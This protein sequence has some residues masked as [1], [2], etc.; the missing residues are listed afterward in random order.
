MDQTQKKKKRN[1]IL[2]IIGISVLILAIIGIILYFVL[3][4]GSSDSPPTPPP[5]DTPYV[6]FETDR[7]KFYSRNSTT[8]TTGIDINGDLIE[9]GTPTE[10]GIKTV[11]EMNK[12]PLTYPFGHPYW[13]KD[14]GNLKDGT[15]DDYIKAHSKQNPNNNFSNILNTDPFKTSFKNDGTGVLVI[16]ASDKVNPDPEYAH[17]YSPVTLDIEHLDVEGLVIRR[18][19]V[20]LISSIVKTINTQFILVESGGLLQAGSSFGNKGR[21][22]GNLTIT[23]THPDGGYDHMGS[24]ASQYSYRVYAPGTTK[25]VD[26]TA[27]QFSPLLLVVIWHLLIHL[28]QR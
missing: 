18:G 20:L 25:E 9:A 4:S 15:W 2:L 27:Y 3:S 12:Y 22:E 28:V 17:N 16:H 19:G 26:S 13:D 8:G 5:V 10:P 11:D 1:K 21:F 23:L 24:V 14:T 6:R 7:E